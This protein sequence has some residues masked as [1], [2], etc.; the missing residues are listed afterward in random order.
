MA[1]TLRLPESLDNHLT[2]LANDL[3]IS[4][5]QAATLA[6]ESF[7][8]SHNNRRELRKTIELVTQRDAGLMAR[9]ADS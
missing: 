4:K 1:M 3:G 6:L 7:V 2:A 5:Q 8:D 9:L